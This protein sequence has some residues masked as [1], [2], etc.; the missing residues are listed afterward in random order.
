[1]IR[2]VWILPKGDLNLVVGVVIGIG[3][4]SSVSS[5]D[6]LIDSLT[7]CGGGKS[8]YYKHIYLYQ[9]CEDINEIAFTGYDFLF[10]YLTWM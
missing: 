4:K 10:K 1:M 7:I 6:L 9:C 8:E 2:I 5:T 3:P